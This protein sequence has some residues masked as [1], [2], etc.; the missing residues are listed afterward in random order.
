[1]RQRENRNEE[2][3]VLRDE[4]RRRMEVGETNAPVS[5]HGR[6][7]SRPETCPPLATIFQLDRSRLRH[8]SPLL[9]PPHGAAVDPYHSHRT[10]EGVGVLDW[11]KHIQTMPD[12][13]I[14][15]LFGPC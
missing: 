13:E 8:P 3:M 6:T 1:M 15:P 4:Q 10:E 11:T 7:D 9:N 5:P 14:T 12:M 2:L